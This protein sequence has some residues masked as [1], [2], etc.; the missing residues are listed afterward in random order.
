M[1]QMS[2]QNTNSVVVFNGNKCVIFDPWGRLDDW[3]KYLAERGELGGFL[4]RHSVGDL[5]GKSEVDVSLT[6]A[7]YYFLEALIRLTK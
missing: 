7:D 5:P 1:I 4:L 3:K 2:P 6:Y